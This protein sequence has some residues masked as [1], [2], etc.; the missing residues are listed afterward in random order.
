M[1]IL[2]PSEDGGIFLL[3]KNAK[4][5]YKSNNNRNIIV[6]MM[7]VCSDKIQIYLMVVEW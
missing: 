2:P 6:N 1:N 5:L 4:K 3:N 7:R